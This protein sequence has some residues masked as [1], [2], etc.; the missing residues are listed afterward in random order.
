MVRSQSRR[1]GQE[2]GLQGS[3]FSADRAPSSGVAASSSTGCEG[4]LEGRGG[5]RLA[6]GILISELFLTWTTWLSIQYSSLRA[7]FLTWCPQ[8]SKTCAP[9]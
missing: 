8:K 7:I 9:G 6:S 3:D 5:S 1:G 4:R 2:T